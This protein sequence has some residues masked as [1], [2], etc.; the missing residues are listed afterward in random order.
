MLAR[1]GRLDVAG[2]TL[3]AAEN[4]L[5]STPCLQDL[6]GAYCSWAMGRDR[7]RA[8][9]WAWC[10]VVQSGRADDNRLT[11]L[12]RLGFAQRFGPATRDDPE[13]PRVERQL[14]R[15]ADP[16][17]RPSPGPSFSIVLRDVEALGYV[18]LVQ[19]G[20]LGPTQQVP[21]VQEVLGD[22]RQLGG[23]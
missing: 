5:H 9:R 4:P 16:A 13:W 21:Q 22:V 10:R 6:P 23:A 17:A 11:H 19:H 20:G 15:A 2:K 18:V 3:R 1:A 7:H 12:G 14:A 8:S